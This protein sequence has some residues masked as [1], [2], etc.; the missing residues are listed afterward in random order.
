M[1]SFDTDTES[2]SEGAT[3]N[4]G[5]GFR[6]S[7]EEIDRFHAEGYLGPFD[8]LDAEALAAIRPTFQNIVGGG[9]TSPIYD[10]TTHRDWHLHY[11]NLLTM[12]YRPQLLNRVQ[13]LLGENLLVWRSSI[14]HKAPGD[15]A[16]AWHQSSLFAGEEYGIFR[17]ALAPPPEYEVYTDLFNLS[18]WIALDDVTEANGAMQ[19]AVGTHN[20]QYPVRRVPLSDSIFGNVF[21]DNLG[22]AGDTQRLAEL[23][24]RFACVTIFDPEEE[25][26]EVRTI[27][28]KAG[29]FII[30]TDRVMHSS[31]ANTTEGDRRLAINF[32]ITVPQV[33]VYPHQ[34][35]GEMIDGND[36]DITKHANVMLSGQDRYGKNKYL[37]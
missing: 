30:F 32:R 8:L 24:Q 19:I 5:T 15:G 35:W 6:L 36:H 2:P 9:L 16:L 11:K 21:K 18:A 33:E 34:A 1:T 14:F 28:L 22:R 25:G 26:V 13:S 10:R 23:D 31:L 7:P 17:P 20:K 29:Q 27:E 4:P 12:A 37:N 3:K